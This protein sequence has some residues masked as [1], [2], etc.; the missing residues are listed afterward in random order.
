MIGRNVTVHSEKFIVEGIQTW[1]HFQNCVLN[2]NKIISDSA[3]SGNSQ[4]QVIPVKLCLDSTQIKGLMSM[5]RDY[6]FELGICILWQAKWGSL[7]QFQGQDQI[8]RSVFCVCQPQ[9]DGWNISEHD[10]QLVW[11]FLI[12]QN[13]LKSPSNFPTSKKCF[14]PWLR[15]RVA[16]DL[17]S[18]PFSIPSDF[19][20]IWIKNTCHKMVLLW[21]SRIFV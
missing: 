12:A 13:A 17:S 6:D 19:V 16:F 3:I 7:V 8:R 9:S 4:L 10:L 5:W 1:F 20:Q 18:L 11:D 2:M 21:I 15:G 14:L